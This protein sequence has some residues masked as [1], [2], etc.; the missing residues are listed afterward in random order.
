[1]PTVEFETTVAA[2]LAKVWAFFQDV[3]TSLPAL[4]SPAE[5]V[6]VASADVPM[7]EGSRIVMGMNGP[8]GRVR[9]EAKIVEH[10]PPHA[11]VFGEEARFVDEQETGPFKSW[12]HAHE[13]EATDAKTTRVVDRI[14]YR[15]P[16]GPIGWVA[17]WVLVRRRLRA[18]FRYRHQQLRRLF[19][20]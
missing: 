5:Q 10:V 13:F 12:R 3:E 16:F 14:T 8:F 6:T 9:W 15:V 11:V 18:A 1:M 17:D 4:T 19:D 2:P 7:K 20:S